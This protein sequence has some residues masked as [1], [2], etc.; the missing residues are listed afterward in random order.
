MIKR[1]PLS[2]VIPTKDR[3]RLL[4]ES[5]KFLN[6]NFFFFNEVIIVDSSIK[7]LNKKILYKSYKKLN[8][9]YY[10]S[11]PSTS[12]QRNLGL[13]NVRKKNKFVM[14]L[15]DDIKFNHDAFK[16]M[17]TFIIKKGAS[18]AGIGF[19]SIT[20][21]RYKKNLLERIKNSDFFTRLGIYDSRPGMVT[22]SGWQTK[23]LNI[24]KN[25]L[26]EWLP[27]QACIYRRD[28]IK[29]LRFSSQLGAYAYL[30]DLLFSH[31]ISKRGDLIIHFEAKYKDILTVQ[32]NHFLFG[33]KEVRNRIVF[34]KKNKLSIGK[35]LLGYVFF[36][37]KNFLEIFLNIKKIMRFFG[38]IIGIIYLIKLK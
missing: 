11:K 13:R 33:I 31:E 8:I 20:K 28:K 36:L 27:T 23:I 32:R 15:D 29:F 3:E 4:F 2:I 7:K 25:T 26:V 19:N 30:E 35:F 10:T 22:S 5:L 24:K 17:Y 14:F 38:N 21:S 37:F 9:Q 16:K 6:K 18:V 12:V 34:V 1:L